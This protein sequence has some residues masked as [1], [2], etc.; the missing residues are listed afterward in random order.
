VLSAVQTVSPRFAGRLLGRVMNSP[1]WARG[2]ADYFIRSPRQGLRLFA[3]FVGAEHRGT[4]LEA[5][6]ANVVEGRPLDQLGS[7]SREENRL[8]GLLQQAYQTNQAPANL[9]LR[10]MLKLSARHLG[11]EAARVTEATP[12]AELERLRRERLAYFSL[13]LLPRTSFN[14]EAVQVLPVAT[15]RAER[16]AVRRWPR[17]L[18]APRVMVSYNALYVNPNLLQVWTDE[19]LGAPPVINDLEAYRNLLKQPMRRFSTSA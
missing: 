15:S 4:H 1:L 2:F 13:L 3:A 5:M 8:V 14:P 6:L 16:G 10:R 11:R 19:Y 17:M 9:T 18:R 12:P 7:Y